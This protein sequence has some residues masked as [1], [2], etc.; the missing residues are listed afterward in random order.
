MR[1]NKQYLKT[2]SY[3][4]T[5]IIKLSYILQILAGYD[6]GVLVGCTA[7]YSLPNHW[8][9][10][11][12]IAYPRALPVVLP[13]VQIA[14]M[15]SVYCTIV[16]SFERYVRICHICQLQQSNFNVTEENVW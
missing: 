8:T 12:D 9:W 4:V 10:F 15:T 2:Q 3:L 11:L 16:M 14:M 5:I 7:L 13:L 1:E 6:L